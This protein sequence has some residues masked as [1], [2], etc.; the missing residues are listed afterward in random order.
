MAKWAMSAPASTVIAG[1]ILSL[2]YT[3]LKFGSG[4]EIGHRFLVFHEGSV[5]EG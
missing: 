1:E 5:V 2:K 3:H 4:E